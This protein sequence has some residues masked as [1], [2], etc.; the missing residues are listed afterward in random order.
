MSH[1]TKEIL[2]A[3]A[4][5]RPVADAAALFAGVSPQDLGEM[6][7]CLGA[8]IKHVEKNEIVLLAGSRPQQIGLVLSGQFLVTKDA[9]DG[10]RTLMAQ[11]G[12]GEL[13]AET[14]CCAHV[15]ES[16][17][18]VLASE[19]SA[20]LLLRFPRLLQT[21]PSACSHHAKLV[22]NMLGIVAQKALFLQQRIEILRTR[23]IC[24]KVLLYLR[25]FSPAPG[26]AFTVPLNRDEMAE[27]LGAE[28]SA[29]SHELS[30]MKRDGVLDY[31]KNRF[32]LF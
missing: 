22:E 3:L 27:F 8:E 14:L 21:C 30:R 7:A 25:P 26:K 10:T 16:P 2:S 32:V 5:Y 24:E 23:A 31:R 28:R 29:L 1:G 13:F 17:V 12:P 19:E 11:L 4:P 15:P 18:T 6:L 9:A 20:V